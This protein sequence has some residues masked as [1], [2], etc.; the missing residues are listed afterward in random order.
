[1]GYDRVIMLETLTLAILGGLG[2]LFLLDVLLGLWVFKL[3][4]RL[5]LFSKK[6]S[7]NLEEFLNKQIEKSEKQDKD[8]ESIFKEILRLSAISKKSFQKIGV[9][10]F[11]PF[12]EVGGDQSFSI[13]LLDAQNNGFVITGLYERETNR[14]Y[15][16]PVENSSS[17]YPLSEEEKQ[18]IEK[19]TG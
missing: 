11:N 16:K 8:I 5:N 12:K 17:K 19:A 3:K 6:G 4:K 10:R 7:K 2:I 1:M 15:A 13:A 9:V 14:I 18:A